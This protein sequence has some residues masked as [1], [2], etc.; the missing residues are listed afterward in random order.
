MSVKHMK[1]PLLRTHYEILGL[2]QNCS[3][4]DIREAFLGLSKKI[5]PDLNPEDP[6]C[7]QSFLRLNEAYTVL[8]K[9]DKR[10][11]YDASL[12]QQRHAMQQPYSSFSSSWVETNAPYGR[13]T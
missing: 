13:S 1:D 10:Q 12:M 11:I 3:T 2:Q 5:H 9:P 8:S 4:K 7:H 6:N